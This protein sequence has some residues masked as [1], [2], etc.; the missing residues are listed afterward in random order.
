VDEAWSHLEQYSEMSPI[1][2][3]TPANLKFRTYATRHLKENSWEVETQSWAHHGTNRTLHNLIG[4]KAPGASSNQDI[5]ILGAHYDTRIFSDKDPDLSKRHL[6]VPG[7]ND[8]GSGV[9]VLLELARVL[10]IPPDIEI[11]LVFLDAEDQGQIADWVGGLSDGWCIGSTYFVEQLSPE[12]RQRVRVAIIIDLV[13]DFDL[14]LHKEG[15]SDPKYVQDIWTAAAELGYSDTFL[16]IPGG[17]IIDDHVPFL[18]AG[19]PAVDIIQQT[20]RDGYFFFQW[21]HTTNDTIENVSPSSLEKVGRTLEYYLETE[22]KVP[23]FPDRTIG[24]ITIL[25][26]IIFIIIHKKSTVADHEN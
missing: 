4:K 8:G 24:F 21:H 10:D 16:D 19:I 18:R 7:A 3:D 22:V 26:L 13:G 23:G 1:I 25:A 6:P 2:P 5:V 12:V 17:S 9:V 14:Q 11:W 15:A 20:S